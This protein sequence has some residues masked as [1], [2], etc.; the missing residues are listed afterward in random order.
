M[1]PIVS[2]LWA[3]IILLILTVSASAQ[4]SL[5]GPSAEVHEGLTQRKGSFAKTTRGITNLRD[6]GLHVHTNTTICEE[7]ADRLAG[8]IDLAKSLEL[9]HVSMNHIIPTGTPNL[10]RHERIKVSY[11]EIGGY[12]MRAKAHAEEVGIEF[13]WYSPTPFCIFNPIAHGLATKGVRHA[14]ALSMCRLPAKCCPVRASPVASA[15]CWKRDSTRSGLARTRNSTRR[16]VKPIHCAEGV[17]TL[18]SSRTI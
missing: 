2:Y 15:M 9:P 16:N 14:T 5:E 11:T 6:A 7:N 8:I 10:S 1:R 13:H 18:D 12:V 17:N 3:L 4:V